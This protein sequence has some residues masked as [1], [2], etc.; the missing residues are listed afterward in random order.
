MREKWKLICIFLT[1]FEHKPHNNVLIKV[2]V[3]ISILIIAFIVT[4]IIAYKFNNLNNVKSYSKSKCKPIQTLII[5][6]FLN[7]S[8]LLLSVDMTMCSIL[9]SLLYQL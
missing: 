1:K 2:H 6:I 7:K 9:C 5:L 4:K 8:S 3:F